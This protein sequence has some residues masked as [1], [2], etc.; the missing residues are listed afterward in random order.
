MKRLSKLKTKYGKAIGTGFG[1]L[2]ASS[3]FIGGTESSFSIFESSILKC[4]RINTNDVS[5]KLI[6]QSILGK[7]VIEISPSLAADVETEISHYDST[8][9]Y[10]AIILFSGQRV[11]FKKGFYPDE[12]IIDKVHQ[13]NTFISDSE[14]T[15]LSIRQDTPRYSYILGFIYAL[16]GGGSIAHWFVNKIT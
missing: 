13:I 1:L 16:I 8:K 3:F 14:S 9:S 7:K 4:N 5:C 10:R 15:Y 2:I 12:S 6:K 11:P